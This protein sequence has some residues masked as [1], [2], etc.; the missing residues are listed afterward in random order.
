[1]YLFVRDIMFLI[2]EFKNCL[3]IGKN[4]F[5]EELTVDSMY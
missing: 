2:S 5:W 3:I 4:N 1:M